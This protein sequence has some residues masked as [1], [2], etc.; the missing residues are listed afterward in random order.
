MPRNQL[1]LRKGS[2]C[3]IALTSQHWLGNF[4]S[5][6]CFDHRQFILDALTYCGT[7]T[8]V[9]TVRGV[10]KRGDVTGEYRNM[11]LQGISL[12]AKPTK[13]MVADVL[14]ITQDKP[15]R[16]AYL[17][18]GTLIQR[19]CK[20]DPANC[21]YA[22]NNPI[23]KAEIFLETKLG[24]NCNE[25]DDD[26]RAEEILMALKAIANARQPWRVKDVLLGCVSESKH[27]N[28]TSAALDA[29]K[30]LPC[31]EN[32]QSYL[33]KILED[34]NN[35][36]EKRIH[37]YVALMNC[38]RKPTLERVVEHLTNEKSSQVGSFMLSHLKNI[39][40]SSDPI[41]NE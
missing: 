15:S 30:R 40:E 22:K 26:K 13:Q 24:N 18:L 3:E 36:V 28:I 21:A 1:Y 39:L 7:P 35:D 16:Q 12:V 31:D 25:Q 29:L 19:Y 9:T 34:N 2:H 17:A 14:S 41:H 6:L 10:I 32:I 23:T 8:C 4:T 27:M 20:V 11:F 38:P 37:T 33:H 5:F